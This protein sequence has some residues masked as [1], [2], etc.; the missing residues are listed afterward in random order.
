MR[1]KAVCVPEEGTESSI[2]KQRGCL[3]FLQVRATVES[4]ADRTIALKSTVGRG[5]LELSQ[6]GCLVV[7]K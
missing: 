2:E 5:V 1:F 7:L 4:G 6:E 3:S